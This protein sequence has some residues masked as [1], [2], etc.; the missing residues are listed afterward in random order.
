M[1]V[2]LTEIYGKKVKPGDKVV[3]IKP[4]HNPYC[5]V[6][7]GHV[8]TYIG[9]DPKHNPGGILKDEETGLIFKQICTLSYHLYEPSIEIAKK[10]YIDTIE[11]QKFLNFIENRCPHRG[12]SNEHFICKIQQGTKVFK[13]HCNPGCNC[14]E[15]LP[16][17]LYKDNFFIFNYKRKIK[18]K[19]IKDATKI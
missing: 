6:T 8:L 13:N 12:H 19:K 14:I 15:Q 3:V 1:I 7:I 10:K 5:I 2:P 17:K 18:M 11:K 9:D 16:E 4:I